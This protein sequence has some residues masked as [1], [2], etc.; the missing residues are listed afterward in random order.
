MLPPLPW[1]S[2]MSP[3]SGLVDVET[4]RLIKHPVDLGYNLASSACKAV[5]ATGSWGGGGPNLIL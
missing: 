5:L 4:V 3:D 2:P 1:A